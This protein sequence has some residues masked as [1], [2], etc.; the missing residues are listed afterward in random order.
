LINHNRRGVLDHRLSRVTTAEKRRIEETTA[1]Q[2]LNE[3]LRPLL[4]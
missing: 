4:A 3:S 1:A 2:G